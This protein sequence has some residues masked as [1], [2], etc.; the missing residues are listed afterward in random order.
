MP[1]YA[2][3]LIGLAAIILLAWIHHGPLGG[4]ARLIDRLE[5]EARAAV[6]R[7]QVPGVQVRLGRDPLSRG[8]TLS[9]PADRFQR[10]GQGMQKGLNDVVGEVEGITGVS[11][12]N[13]PPAA[14]APDGAR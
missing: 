3:F 11:W 6:A 1:A 9:G 7:T 14:P 13:P 5:G 8:A 4:G 12:S 10:E 2:K